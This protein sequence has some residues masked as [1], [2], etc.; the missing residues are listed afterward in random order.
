M[1][2][3]DPT[4]PAAEIKYLKALERGKGWPDMPPDLVALKKKE[5]PAV[6]VGKAKKPPRHVAQTW[7][8]TPMEARP[9]VPRGIP[10][11]IVARALLLLV[12][13]LAVALLID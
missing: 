8:L 7:G 10:P 6:P 11:A 12:V 5:T 3:F 1:S 13:A 4:D 2:H 9:F